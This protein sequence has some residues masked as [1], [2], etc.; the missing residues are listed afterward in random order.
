MYKSRW[1]V[2]PLIYFFDYDAVGDHSQKANN[3]KDDFN[4]HF[5]AFI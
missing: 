4:D 3:Q 2:F 5:D 1:Y